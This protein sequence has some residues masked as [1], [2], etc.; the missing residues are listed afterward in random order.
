MNNGDCRRKK[1]VTALSLLGT[2]LV[3]ASI[4]FNGQSCDATIHFS[5]VRLDRPINHQKAGFIKHFRLFEK[6]S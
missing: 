3:N 5:G 1:A 4:P 6:R 2:S